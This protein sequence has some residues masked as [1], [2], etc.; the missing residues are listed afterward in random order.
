MLNA[1][2]SHGSY[3]AESST[4]K[5]RRLLTATTQAAP[6]RP[7]KRMEGFAKWLLSALAPELPE[8]VPASPNSRL[9]PFEGVLIER[10]C[11]SGG[12]FL[13]GYWFTA[14]G[15]AKGAVLMV[16]PWLH[17]GQGFLHRR[18]RVETLRQAGYHVLTFD[19]GGFGHSGPE[20]S[21]FHDRDIEDALAYLR[22]RAA[23]LSC[24]LWG[25]SAGGA[26][27]HAVLSRVEGVSGAVFEDVP[28]SLLEWSRR[29][30]PSGLPFYLFF[31]HCLPGAYRFLDQRYHA[32]FLKVRAVTY[33][34]CEDDEGAPIGETRRLAKLADGQFLSIPGIG[35]LGAL[36][37]ER[38][39][40]FDKVLET[41]ARAV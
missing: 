17:W 1:L 24:H 28:Q 33:I 31:Q 11:S 2:P 22:Q 4:L 3:S 13:S 12:G 34:G 29:M 5:F 15:E 38:Q 25:V 36:V 26:W 27:S 20:A 37:T 35:H 18:G 41:F 32:P 8:L 7:T 19:L 14:E 21:C 16:H 9:Q 23:G 39:R 40:V 10:R 30:S 6:P